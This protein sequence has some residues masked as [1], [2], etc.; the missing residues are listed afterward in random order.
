M[1]PSGYPTGTC[2]IMRK[3]TTWDILTNEML[4][5]S[6]ILFS[7]MP[8][9]FLCFVSIPPNRLGIW[10]EVFMC[11]VINYNCNYYYLFQFGYK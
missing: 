5:G 8:H 9:S 3:K 10:V 1:I 6:G 11:L 4:A 7:K 2:H